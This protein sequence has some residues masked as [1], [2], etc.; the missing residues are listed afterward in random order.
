MAGHLGQRA[1]ERQRL[2]AIAAR[3][4]PSAGHHFGVGTYEIREE[5]QVEFSTL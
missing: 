4:A 1:D 2:E 3:P 5:R